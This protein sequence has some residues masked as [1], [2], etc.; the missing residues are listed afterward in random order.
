MQNVTPEEAKEVEV[1]ISALRDQKNDGVHDTVKSYILGLSLLSLVGDHVLAK[2]TEQLREVLSPP[3]DRPTPPALPPSSPISS[4]PSSPPSPAPVASRSLPA[5]A[6][7]VLTAL[8]V[9]GG[10]MPLPKLRAEVGLSLGESPIID[11]LQHLG[12]ISMDGEKG[13]ETVRILAPGRDDQVP[14]RAE[15]GRTGPPG[16]E[17]LSVTYFAYGSNMSP[18][19]IAAAGKPFSL[20][21]AARLD[22]YRLDFTRQSVL[23]GTGVADIVGADDES[24]WGVAYRVSRPGLAA[25]DRKE[26]APQAYTQVN[27]PVKLADDDHELVAVSYTVRAKRSFVPPSAMY[28]NRM[29]EM[30]RLFHF[31]EEYQTQLKSV[32]TAGS[33]A[34][35]P[36]AD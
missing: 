10:A 23:T 6:E 22:G 30:A 12:K 17:V 8:K 16:D 26:G 36:V 27:V 13:S 3:G 33:A 35:Q 18:E 15:P 14:P 25:L 28:L 24:V 34:P 20:L 29:V 11:D 4:P 7:D 32:E 2:A 31:P 19:V 1:K 21:G 5:K 9:A